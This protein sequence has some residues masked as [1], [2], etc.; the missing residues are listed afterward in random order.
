MKEEVLKSKNQRN[1]EEVFTVY[2]WMIHDLKLSG[3]KLNV[4]AYIYKLTKGVKYVGN[5]ELIGLYTGTGISSILSALG[6]L[7]EQKYIFT[8]DKK[9]EY[10]RRVET[11][12]KS[13]PEFV[14]RPIP[15]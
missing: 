7:I 9:C 8:I 12:Y 11:L 5:Q 1:N 10:T 2:S 15:F 3:H 13:N 4:Y 14:N 6:K